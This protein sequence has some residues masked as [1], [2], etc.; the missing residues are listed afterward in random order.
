[1][2]RFSHDVPDVSCSYQMTADSWDWELK[3][4]LFG[5]IPVY[6]EKMPAAT[7]REEIV[8]RDVPVLKNSQQRARN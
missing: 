4:V 3:C 2:V 8:S 5:S 1:L 7:G 6:E